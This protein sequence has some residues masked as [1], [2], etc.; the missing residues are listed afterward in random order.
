M[1][2]T[3]IIHVINEEPIVG[4]V[5]Q[6]PGPSDTLI[7]IQNPRRRDGKE[8]QNLSTDAVIVIWPVSQISFMEVMLG[9]S[10]EPIIGFVRE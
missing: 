2:H 1:A 5:D 6:L 4:E 8:I 9:E 7:S 10:E 3:L